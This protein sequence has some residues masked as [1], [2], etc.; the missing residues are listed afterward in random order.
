MRT[1]LL[2]VSAILVGCS[3]D[4]TSTPDGSATGTGGS[5]SAA[6]NGGTSAG[7]SSGVGAGGKGAG[8]AAATGGVGG[9]TAGTGTGGSGTAGSGVAGS[10]ASGGSAASGGSGGSGTAGSDAAGSSGGPPGGPPFGDSSKGSGG[11]APVAGTTA[12]AGGITYRLIVPPSPAKPAPLLVIYSGTEGGAQMT[13]NA[14]SV[15]PLT[16][17]DGFLVAVL[18]GVTYNGNGMAGATV[19]DDVRAKYDIDNDRTYLLGESAGTTAAF[20]LGFHLREAWFAAY[21]ANDVNAV[22]GPATPAAALGFAPSGQ[23]GPGGQLATAQ[24]IVMKM[25]TAGYQVSMPAPYNG[26]GSTTHGDPQQFIAAMT[27]FPGKTR[28]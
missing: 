2:L 4:A 11:P 21:W 28:K 23:V 12:Q 18:D 5:M 1:P 13:M 19:L 9:G 3:S 7:G 15:G 14:K 16:K 24:Q 8:G 26:P 10:G 25:Q 22:D 17:T 6:G 27:W 20:A